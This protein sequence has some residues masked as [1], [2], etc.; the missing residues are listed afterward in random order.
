M[1]IALVVT[2]TL[3]PTVGG[4][5]DVKMKL[6]KY[7]QYLHHLKANW[8]LEKPRKVKIVSGAA[9]GQELA[10]SDSVSEQ[11]LIKLGS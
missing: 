6:I 5:K 8:F 9:F 1:P 10:L 2:F 7:R 4:P 3:R 11:N